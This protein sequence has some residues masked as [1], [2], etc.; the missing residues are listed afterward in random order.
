MNAV[1]IIS[2]MRMEQ[3]PSEKRMR[4]LQNIVSD[5]PWFAIGHQLLAIEIQ[6]L[7]NQNFEKYL[8]K[9]AIYTINRELLYNKLYDESE[10]NIAKETPQ[11][12]IE[13][14]QNTV[15]ETPQVVI[16]EIQNTVEEKSQILIEET[17]NAV[18]HSIS[19]NQEFYEKKEPQEITEKPVFEYHISDYLSTQTLNINESHDDILDKFLASSQKISAVT[20]S[21][22]SNINETVITEPTFEDDFVTETLAKIYTVQGYFSK[23]IEVYEK[24]SLQDSKKSVYF[25]TLIEN[26]KKKNKT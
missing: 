6:K 8:H 12:V 20:E 23:A 11:V 21:G 5:N 19:E 17:Q 1:N 26:L 10:Q 3:K 25:A 15:E 22:D 2:M 9:A 13:E 14:T 4:T 16:E 7:D 24:L 18:E